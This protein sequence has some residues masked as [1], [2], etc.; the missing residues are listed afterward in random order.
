MA[1]ADFQRMTL[2]LPQRSLSVNTARRAL[3]LLR[4]DSFDT[5]DQGKI[6]GFQCRSLLGACL[7][8]TGNIDDAI[9]E[10]SVALD[11]LTKA[12]KQGGLFLKLEAA[13]SR[14]TLSQ[15][16]QKTG[17]LPEAFSL[18]ETSVAEFEDLLPSAPEWAAPAAIVA[19][20]VLAEIHFES[21]A[22]KAGI[23]TLLG[24]IRLFRARYDKTP[25]LWFEELLPMCK[26][27][28]EACTSE[29]VTIEWHLVE[30]ILKL[31]RDAGR[32]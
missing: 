30:D 5:S 10:Q 14:T 27:Y 18:A 21:G 31:A 13:V 17:R 28:Y 2:P 32:F 20:R 29:H 12:A 19:F 23:A 15:A 24:G 11:G 8:D 7:Y 25:A 22:Q 4:S 16:L 26:R 9:E 6:L 3:D 1:L